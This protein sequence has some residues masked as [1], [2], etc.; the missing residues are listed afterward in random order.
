MQV[1]SAYRLRDRYFIHPSKRTTEGA[2]VAQPQFVSLPLDSSTETLGHAILA[3]L[4]ESDGTVDHP[5]AWRT[6][7]NA[8]LTAAGVRSERAFGTAARLVVVCR[9][10]SIS[11]EPTH[12][13]GISGAGRGFTSLEGGR[14]TVPTDSTPGI[15]G[16]TF[17][18][19]LEECTH[20]A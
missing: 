18:R 15:V 20:A 1:V 5:T 14:I 11:L 19:V 2:W 9:T 13:G 16:Q 10:D 4:A 7:S 6:F 17:L 3:S 8:R 12:N